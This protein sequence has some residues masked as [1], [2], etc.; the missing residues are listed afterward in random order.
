MFGDP[1]S[2]VEAGNIRRDLEHMALGSTAGDIELLADPWFHTTE[3][4]AHREIWSFHEDPVS[5]ENLAF[6]FPFHDLYAVGVFLTE[7][8]RI[9]PIKRKLT[10]CLCP[11]GATALDLMIERLLVSPENA[12][13]KSM[14]DLY[15]DWDKLRH[16]YLAPAEV[17]ELSLAAEFK[18][19]LATPAGRVVI[20]PRLSQLVEHKLFQRL[21]EAPQLELL[22]L[23]Y[24]GATHTRQEHS[25]LML[26][27]TR[28]YLAHLL[29]GPVFR[30][31]VDKPELEATLI[32]S[33]LQ[34]IGHYQLSHFFEDY[35]VE[36]R[37][38]IRTGRSAGMWQYVN[39]DIP[40][41]K[42]LFLSAFNWNQPCALRGEYHEVIKKACSDSCKAL[43]LGLGPNLADLVREESSVA[44]CE[45][46]LQIYETAYR[47]PQSAGPGHRV[48]AATLSSEVD[49]DKVSY[50]KEDA[51]E[52]GVRFG[53]GIDLDGL[54]G[55]LRAPSPTDLDGGTGVAPLIGITDKG[56]SAVESVLYNRNAMYERVYWHHSTRSIAAMIK[57]CITRLI[58]SQT[59]SMQEFLGETFFMEQAQALRVL[60][61]KYNDIMPPG[62]VN[63]ISHLLDGERGVYK[64]AHDTS[65][66]PYSELRAEGIVA[67]EEKLTRETAEKL[68]KSKLRPGQLVVDV[69]KPERGIVAS[70][71]ET[72]FV[73]E[74]SA[75]KGGKGLG[76]VSEVVRSI[77]KS[78]QD[79]GKICR[80]F[81]SRDT[82][83]RVSLESVKAT[84][85]DIIGS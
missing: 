44:T 78:H 63:P 67:L 4:I 52:T 71:P 25:L 9:P 39:Y 64:F 43:G 19:S 29:N 32:L 55:A 23:K 22:R 40:T 26:R 42:D 17:P 84:L 11:S 79:H 73:Y 59:F 51:A 80:V 53:E 47:H 85:K 30:F 60:W 5:P 50:L 14:E 1:G 45:A 6:I 10:R 57:Y 49:A 56:I 21:R 7:L 15:S 74:G 66:A 2:S 70:S 28:Y 54:L 20:T 61:A 76:E 83:E 36:Q 27:N 8:L 75:R 24:T 37:N 34:G 38:E 46:I 81:V 41:D 82:L 58:I 68:P 48:L 62:S 18:Y 69:P 13:Y 31:M 3:R 16:G 12:Y 33:L 77:R 35:A 72:V 65:S